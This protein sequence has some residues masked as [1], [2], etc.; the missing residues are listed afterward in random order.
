MNFR[1]TKKELI[2]SIIFL[3]VTAAL[4][5]VYLYFIKPV[6]ASLQTAESVLKQE[7]A[8]LSTV[9]ASI[10]NKQENAFQGTMQLQKKLPVEPL[11]EQF[12]LDLEKA[13]IISGSFITSMSFGDKGTNEATDLVEE[14][15][16]ETQ[17]LLEGNTEE[18]DDVT[19]AGQN[20]TIEGIIPEGIKRLTVNLTVKSP[21]YFELEAFIKALEDLRR[22][23][24]VDELS[25]SGNEELVTT[26]ST[27]EHLTYTLTVSAFFFPKLEV[28]R[29]QL[30]PFEIPNPSQKVNPLVPLVS[31]ENSNRSGNGVANWNESKD[32]E[33]NSNVNEDETTVIIKHKVK[34]G[35]TLFR[36]SQT[37]YKNRSGEEIIKEINNLE[38]NTLY[39]GQVLKIPIEKE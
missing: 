23:T 12:L 31:N 16:K 29:E 32:T 2:I 28:L 15:L 25:F 10:N 5:S 3:L 22:I 35:E 19:Q 18:S 14:Y 38:G 33:E 17:V 21:S 8:L 1:L 4:A 9:E 34:Q 36:I 37:Y 26:D 11:L 30:P 13:E 6:R 7:E 39:T 20:A 24:K 27:V